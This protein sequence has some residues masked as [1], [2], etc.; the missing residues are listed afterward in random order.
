MAIITLLTDFGLED[1]F[2]GQMHGVILSRCPEAKIVD[3]THGV[4]PQDVRQASFLL[5][6]SYEWFP[7]G[8]VHVA[9][10]DPGVGSER[11]GIVVEAQGHVF[12]APDNGLCT[13]LFS[14]ARV[15]RIDMGIA[16]RS[17]TFHGRDLFAPVGAEIASGRVAPAEVGP[18]HEP[19]KLPPAAKGRVMVVDHFGNLIT[20]LEADGAVA[21]EIAGRRIPV[22][23]TYSDVAVGELLALTSSFDT[24]EIA[25]REGNASALLSARVGAEVRVV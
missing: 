10:V 6:R 8:S 2:V 5:A 14:G 3:L 19:V 1:P 24:L 4:Q 16:P 20:D 25:C 22:R 12:V 18:P 17:R 9:V 23:G 15:H 13:P 21:V 7:P 11:A